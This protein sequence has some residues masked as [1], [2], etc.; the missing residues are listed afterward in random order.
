MV[1]C[2]IEEKS[3]IDLFEFDNQDRLTR[4][5]EIDEAIKELKQEKKRILN[6]M[7]INDSRHRHPDLFK[8]E[9]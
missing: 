5:E 8:E 3:E 7:D 4:L 1:H 9:I 6:W 2:K